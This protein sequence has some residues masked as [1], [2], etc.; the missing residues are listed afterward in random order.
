MS[1]AHGS[2]ADLT[3]AVFCDARNAMNG[4]V[5]RRAMLAA[6]YRKWSNER[7]ADVPLP[8]AA[9]SRPAELSLL[10]AERAAEC[11][12]S[13]ILTIVHAMPAEL[14][15]V[16]SLFY[17][18]ELGHADI[19]RILELPD[20]TVIARLAEAKTMLRCRLETQRAQDGPSP[21]PRVEKTKGGPSE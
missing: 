5:D 2:A 9:N 3:E 11:D 7:S 20:E 18:E 16:L 19:A 10:T 13:T 15:L 17:F 1:L 21:S 12:Q 8:A 4:V 14:R 6:L